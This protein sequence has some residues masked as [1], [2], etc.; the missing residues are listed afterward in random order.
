MPNTMLYF[1]YVL[2]NFHKKK[3]TYQMLL[4]SKTK[5]SFQADSAYGPTKK[6]GPKNVFLGFY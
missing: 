4:S 3:Y 1:S 2:Q 6:N 5:K